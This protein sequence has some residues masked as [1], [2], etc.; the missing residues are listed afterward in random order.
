MPPQVLES[1]PEEQRAELQKAMAEVQE[2]L[3]RDALRALDAVA[4]STPSERE[5]NCA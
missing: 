5:M 4:A 2:Q 1:L 3:V